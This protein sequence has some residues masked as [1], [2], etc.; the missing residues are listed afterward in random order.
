MEG[1]L[2]G[3]LLGGDSSFHQ[4]LAVVPGDRVYMHLTSQR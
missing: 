4:G 3:T 1:R 2:E